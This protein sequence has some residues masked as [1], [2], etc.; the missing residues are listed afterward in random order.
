MNR[1]K[2]S[3]FTVVTPDLTPEEL[4]A[5]AK[6]AGLQG[7][8]WRFKDVPED[9]RQEAPSFWRNNLASIDPAASDEEL[10]RFV[11]ATQ[12]NGLVVA[13]L[14]P[15]LNC[16]DVEATEHVMRVAKRIGAP[17]I[18]AGVPRYDGT[19]DYNT[20]YDQAVTYLHAVEELS[21]TYGVKALVE[22]HHVTIAPSAGLAHRLVSRFNPE[23]VGVLF[24][25]GNMIHEGFEHFRMGMELL[26]PYLAHVHVK[27]A[28][29]IPTGSREAR[30]QAWK[31][32]WSP[33]KEGIVPWHKVVAD[34]KAVGYNGW[35]GVEDFSGAL[36]SKE[37]LKTYVQYMKE[38]YEG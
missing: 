7:I 26:G 30:A 6:E 2:L 8:E 17:A 34:L 4:C 33:M 11:K 29:W 1:L 10:N 38:W 35:F 32:V 31:S 19:V 27:N 15:Y 18:R 16:G 13:G 37:L 14:T 3:V 5:S 22:T 25:P 20:L 21:K 28:A 23:H 24:D 12:D 9:A 36:S